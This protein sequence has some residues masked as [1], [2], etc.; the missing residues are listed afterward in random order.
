MKKEERKHPLDP[1]AMD[2]E[3]RRV[4]DEIAERIEEQLPEGWTTKP[5]KE[6]KK[7]AQEEEDINFYNYQDLLDGAREWCES[8]TSEIE[9]REKILKRLK[10]LP[11]LMVSRD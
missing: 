10:P 3:S 1:D 6:F 7:W 2:P 5:P 8:R 11:I 9:L 4:Y